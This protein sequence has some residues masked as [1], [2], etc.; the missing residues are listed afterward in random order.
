MKG[1][2]IKW[3]WWAIDW[4]LFNETHCGFRKTFSLFNIQSVRTVD[5][6]LFSIPV[7]DIL[8]KSNVH[9]DN[10]N[11]YQTVYVDMQT[12]Q[13]LYEMALRNVANRPSKICQ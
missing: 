1:L 12:I 4:K 2:L 6:G 7:T 13:L 10:F 5:I 9:L 3:V 11:W 8:G